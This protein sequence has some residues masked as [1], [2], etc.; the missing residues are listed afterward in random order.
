MKNINNTNYNTYNQINQFKNQKIISN[1]N[2][3]TVKNKDREKDNQ[4]RS[5]TPLNSR[6]KKYFETSNF[7]I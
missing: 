5:I 4:K 3:K 7:N 6:L 2:R 1:S